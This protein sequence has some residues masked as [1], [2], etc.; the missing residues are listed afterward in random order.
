[1]YLSAYTYDPE[2]KSELWQQYLE[3]TTDYD[4]KK[5]ALMQE[6][7]GYIMF[8]DCSLH[9]A[10]ALVGEGRNGKSIYV[11]AIT[12]VLEQATALRYL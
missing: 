11:N 10:F 1:M 8:T 6:W 2:A 9:K 7:A 3:T 4:D 12:D 5:M